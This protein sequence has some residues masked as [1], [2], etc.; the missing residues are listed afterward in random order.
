MDKDEPQLD[1]QAPRQELSVPRRRSRNFRTKLL[2]RLPT[3]AS[4]QWEAKDTL[5]VYEEIQSVVD[6]EAD[7]VLQPLAP[8]AEQRHE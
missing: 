2:A 5:D 1:L 6:I 4:V 8:L 7:A 3:L